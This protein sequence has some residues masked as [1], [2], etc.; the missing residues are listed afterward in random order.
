MSAMRWPA[1]FGA[2][3]LCLFLPAADARAQVTMVESG[4]VCI[5]LNS[6]TA[7]QIEIG[8]GPDTCLYYGSFDGLKRRCAPN[9]PET[10]CDPAITFPAGIVFTTGG[11][12]GNFMYVADFGLG[13]V[14]RSPG[15]AAGV[16]FT[17]M[18]GPGS[19]VQPPAGSPYG[20]YLYTCEAF[21]GPIYRLNAAGVKTSWLELETCYLKFGPGGAWGTGMYATRYT[22]EQEGIV[23]VS[24]AGAVTPFSNAYLTP[25]G[26]DWG[27][28]GDLFSTDAS[29]GEI[30]RVKSDG[31]KTLFATLN[32]AADVA[33][34]KNEQALYVVSNQGGFYRISRGSGVD[35]PPGAAAPGPRLTVA[36]NP[37]SDACAL[38][39]TLAD[40]GRVRAQ[41]W[42]AAGRRVRSLGD[43]WR[44]AGAQSIAWDG[45]DESGARVRPGTY[46]ARVER[47][48]AVMRARITIVR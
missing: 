8:V 33:Y 4:F 43:A 41:V 15:C 7:K 2:L 21:A 16:L 17:D 42:D 22:F 31:S 9:G 3:L 44:P 27:F 45:R 11:T 40:G 26:F 36:P 29:Y 47:P 18:F 28:D 1:V 6:D 30:Y 23:K 5:L 34:R 38:R 46:F 24:S 35:V 39:F 14:F 10:I 12:F 37:A 25:E 13:D 20:D 32:G 48:G 19:I